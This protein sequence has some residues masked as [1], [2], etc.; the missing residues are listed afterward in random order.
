MQH[1]ETGEV[2]APD[3][4]KLEEEAWVVSLL[5]QCQD[6]GIAFFFK[7]WGGVQKGRHGRSLGGRTYD[8]YPARPIAELPG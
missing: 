8:D 3:G 2:D 5:E 1:S 6:V 4:E 7:Q